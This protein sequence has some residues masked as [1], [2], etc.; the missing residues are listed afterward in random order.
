MRVEFEEGYYETCNIAYR[1]TLL[2]RL[3]GFDETYRLPTGEDTDLAWRAKKT[4][5]RTAF[6]EDALVY[7]EVWP[8]RYL[9]HLRDMGR[10]GGIVHLFSKHPELRAHLRKKLFFRPLHQ[11]AV[12]A[13]GGLIALATR[14]TSD[15]P[16]PARPATG[17]FYA[18]TCRRYR[19]GPPH[20]RDWLA[21]VPFSLRRRPL[22][23]G[24]HGQGV[25]AL[26]DS[27][28]L[29]ARRAPPPSDQRARP[30]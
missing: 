21:V 19:P 17:L 1:R 13:L 3:D 10:R 28:A 23:R 24:R 12:L 11:Q 2:E 16:G 15:W 9:D 22:R 8:S 14:P 4:G 18:W 6:A 26:P 20:R 30:P 25:G 27:P 29:T 7:H 5:A